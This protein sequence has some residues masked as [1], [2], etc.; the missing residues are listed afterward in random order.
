MKI[1]TSSNILV[2]VILAVFTVNVNAF[3]STPPESEEAQS[4]ESSLTYKFDKETKELTFSSYNSGYKIEIFDVEGN[5]ISVND[6]EKNNTKTISTSD[7]LPGK[8]YVRYIG[9]SAKN[10]SV[11]KIV[12]E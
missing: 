9:N 10:N 7:I 2:V 8:Y 1:K 5:T 3:N 11:K 12:I 6:V 4:E